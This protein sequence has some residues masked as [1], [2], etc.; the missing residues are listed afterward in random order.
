L[1][2]LISARVILVEKDLEAALVVTGGRAD[3]VEN[4]LLYGN[5]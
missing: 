3:I 2:E 4:R 5:E 1:T